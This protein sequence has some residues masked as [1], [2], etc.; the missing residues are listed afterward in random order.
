MK[1][2]KTCEFSTLYEDPL[3]DKIVFAIS[4]NQVREKL[5]LKDILTLAKEL[6]RA[7]EQVL[8]LLK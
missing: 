1:T 5:L 7:S 3:K 8:N 6:R 2:T 4:V